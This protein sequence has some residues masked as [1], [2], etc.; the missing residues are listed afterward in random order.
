MEAATE[1]A[2][3]VAVVVRVREQELTSPS[4]AG[5]VSHHPGGDSKGRFAE[6]EALTT[7]ARRR[8]RRRRRDDDGD[9]GHTRR[10]PHLPR[11]L[12]Q[13]SDHRIV[14][15]NCIV[16]PSTQQVSKKAR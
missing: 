7:T 10:K 9:G 3:E 6:A 15:S 14:S 1:V 16:P 13:P 12:L 8:R 2:V 5:N 11:G 4:P